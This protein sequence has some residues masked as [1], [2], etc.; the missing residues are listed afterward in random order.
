MEI[1]RINIDRDSLAI[2]IKMLGFPVYQRPLA[3]NFC[4]SH[5]RVGFH[6]VFL[7]VQLLSHVCHTV[8]MNTFIY[9]IIFSFSLPTIDFAIR[10]RICKKLEDY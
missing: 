7:M 9:A 6:Y 4:S 1:S 3:W 8:R 5:M 10:F 2:L